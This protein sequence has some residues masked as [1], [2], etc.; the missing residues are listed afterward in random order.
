MPRQHPVHD[1]PARK[2]RGGIIALRRPWQ[3]AVFL[4]GLAGCVLLLLLSAILG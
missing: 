3:R 4:A 1:Y 2:A